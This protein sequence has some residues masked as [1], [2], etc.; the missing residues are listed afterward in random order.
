M[1]NRDLSASHSSLISS[2]NLGKTLNTSPS[3]D[4][5]SIAEPKASNISILF[6]FANSHGLALNA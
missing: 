6:I 4:P 2:F 1:A 3:L 5:I